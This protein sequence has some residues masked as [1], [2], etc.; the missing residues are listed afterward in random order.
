MLNECNFRWMYYTSANN[1]QGIN[2]TS[3]QNMH[4]LFS[5]QICCQLGRMR[6]ENTSVEVNHSLRPP[7]TLHMLVS[8]WNSEHQFI[9]RVVMLRNTEAWLGGGWINFT[10]TCRIQHGK[11]NFVPLRLC[12]LRPCKNIN[13]ESW[14]DHDYK[15][16]W[17]YRAVFLHYY[18]DNEDVL[19]THAGK[20]KTLR[21]LIGR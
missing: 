15:W 12:L 21:N 5:W 1:S 6:R 20:K 11:F 18:T 14:K 2:R 19:C 13:I 16:Y 8:N 7:P 4:L 3:L 10:A 17:G 9:S